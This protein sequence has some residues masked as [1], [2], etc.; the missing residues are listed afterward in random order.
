[1]K[2]SV[3]LTE[4]DI[5]EILAAIVSNNYGTEIK[6]EELH[7]QVKSKQNYKSEWEIADIR[8]DVNITRS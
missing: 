2:I 1:M 4:S 7:I 6:P 8:L 5:R 3:Q